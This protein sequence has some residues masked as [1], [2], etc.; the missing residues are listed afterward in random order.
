M[1]GHVHH[2]YLKDLLPGNY[3]IFVQATTDAGDGAAGPRA[4]VHINEGESRRTCEVMQTNVYNESIKRGVFTN[5]SRACF[6][7]LDDISVLMATLLPPLLSSLV[8][9]LIVC[10][11]HSKM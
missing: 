3:R 5:M 9:I 8:L 4:D 7:A 2:L 6:A 1:H 10:L 11:A